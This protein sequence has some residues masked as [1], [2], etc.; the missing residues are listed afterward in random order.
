LENWLPLP[1]LENS[2]SHG[3]L[4]ASLEKRLPPLEK[5]LLPMN[6]WLPPGKLIAF[7]GK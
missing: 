3:E 4:A 5:R 6:N 1:S 2:F 7:P